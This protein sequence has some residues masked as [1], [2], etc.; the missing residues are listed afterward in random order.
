[1]NPTPKDE[2]RLGQD[3]KQPSQQQM[4]G[5]EGKEYGEGNYKATRQYNEGMKE[6]VE[7][8]DVEREARDAAPRNASEEKEMEEAER[9]GRGKS[10]GEGASPDGDTADGPKEK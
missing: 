9:I 8:H 5:G 3:K 4:Q 2:P 7:N 6:H 1:M 10:R